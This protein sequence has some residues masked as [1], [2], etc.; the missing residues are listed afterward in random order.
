GGASWSSGNSTAFTVHRDL[1]GYW[2]ADNPNA[3]F[4]RIYQNSWSKNYTGANDQYAL[5]LSH[6]RIK[7]I[8]LSYKLPTN[9]VNKIRLSNASLNVSVENAGFI[10][11]NSWLKF[12]PANLREGA[13]TYPLQRVFSFGVKIGI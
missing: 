5:D 13:K 1:G 3:F 9:W 10:Y 8:N 4:P 6:L 11:N 7:N 12:D 2:T